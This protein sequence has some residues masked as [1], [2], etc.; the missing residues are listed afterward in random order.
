MGYAI[1]ATAARSGASVTLV[2][3]PVDIAPPPGVRVVQVET[4]AQMRAAVQAE[5]AGAEVFISAAA[6]ADY[7]PASP[8]S[9]KMKKQPGETK[10]ALELLR[11]PDILAEVAASS[12]RP[13]V[14]GFAAETENVEANARLKLE[15]KALDM[16]AAN[17]VGAD[18]GFDRDDNS[19]LVLW[20]GGHEDLGCGSKTALAERLLELIAE[21]MRASHQ[22]E[23]S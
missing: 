21:R 16:I 19:L 4:A 10:L 6:V 5:L 7:R 11:N 1:A 22:A 12:P 2:S 23:D 9:Q 8:A 20:P 17:K 15:T 14:V 18:C 3:G 13:F